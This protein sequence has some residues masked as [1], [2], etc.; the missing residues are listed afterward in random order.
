M[1]N[2]TLN[3]GFVFFANFTTHKETIWV[4]HQGRQS[5]ASDAPSGTSMLCPI[6]KSLNLKVVRLVALYQN[7]GNVGC[8]MFYG[9]NETFFETLDIFYLNRPVYSI[10]LNLFFYFY[11]CRK[12][13]I[14][15]RLCWSS[16]S[17]FSWSASH[18]MLSLPWFLVCNHLGQ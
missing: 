11:T 18:R 15:L 1:W 16:S 9:T 6:K 13:R 12:R 10:Y 3:S 2:F 14:A 5:D 7:I 4:W 8:W 17:L